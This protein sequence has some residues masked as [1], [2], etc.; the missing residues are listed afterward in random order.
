MTRARQQR[1]TLTL[2]GMAALAVG[3]PVGK[4]FFYDPLQKDRQAVRACRE[5]LDALR[6]KKR[7]QEPQAVGRFKDLVSGTLSRDATEVRNRLVQDVTR[8]AVRSKLTTQAVRPRKPLGGKRTKGVL[9]I[10]VS[11][12]AQGTLGNVVR[13]LGEVYELPYLLR[14]RGVRLAR[15]GGRGGNHVSLSADLESLTLPETP[16]S[17]AFVGDVMTFA[18][19]PDSTQHRRRDPSAL[20]QPLAAYAALVDKA[21][22]GFLARAGSP[23]EPQGPDGPEESGPRDGPRRPPPDPRIHV[24][25]VGLFSY[26]DPNDPDGKALIQEVR[27]RGTRGRKPTAV[28]YRVGDELETRGKRN[29]EFNDGRIILVHPYGVVTRLGEQ[30]RLFELDKPL[31]QFQPVNENTNPAIRAALAALDA[32]PSAR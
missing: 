2:A 14:V 24:K 7:R 19:R 10:P 28:S 30:R 26:V 5:T 1:V 9:R 31:S 6:D 32:Q 11:V 23:V 22:F 20:S 12:T 3:W 27:V 15:V 21:P 25:V 13:F 16:E 8:L 4:A 29:Q 17:R 18:S